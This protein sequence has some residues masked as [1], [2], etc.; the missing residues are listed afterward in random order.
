LYY[1]KMGS[2]PEIMTVQYLALQAAI[3][4]SPWVPRYPSASPDDG[5]P[6]RKHHTAMPEGGL[7]VDAGAWGM[8]KTG[9][10]PLPSYLEVRYRSEQ[11]PRM[12]ARPA[13]LS[14]LIWSA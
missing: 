5:K 2:V 11:G 14:G 1:S 13:T 4:D 10:G 9:L 12:S 3:T 8:Q 6:H 7:K